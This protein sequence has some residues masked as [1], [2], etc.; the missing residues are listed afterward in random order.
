MATK[1][2]SGYIELDVRY[3]GAFKEIVAAADRA[4]AEA[5]KRLKARLKGD[6]EVDIDADTSKA[7]RE[8]AKTRAGAKKPVETQLDIDLSDARKQ[9][10]ALRVQQEAKKLGIDVDVDTTKAETQLALLRTRSEIRD[11][12]MGVKVDIGQARTAFSK[13]GTDISGLASSLKIPLIAVGALGSLPALSNGLVEVA[14]SLQKV[15]Q[16]GLVLPGIMAGVGASFGTLLGG[17]TGISDA[18]SALVDANKDAAMST[19]DA[20]TAARAARSAH[21]GLRNAVIDEEQ[22]REDLGR[23]IRDSRREL[24]DLQ[25]QMRG[26]AIDEKRAVLELQ[27]AKEALAKGDYTDRRDA[28]LRVEEAQNRVVDVQER[29]QRAAADLAEAQAK[30][31]QGSDRVVGA[32]EA[33]VRAQ[34]NVAN[35]QDQVTAATEKTSA[36]QQKSN[37]LLGELS[38]NAQKLVETLVGLKEGPVQDLRN[39]ISQTLLEGVP[40]GLEAL[41]TRAMPV[42]SSGTQ[43]IASAWNATIKD[44]FAQL[45]TEQNMGILNNVLDKTAQAMDKLRPGAE[46]FA[47]AMLVITNAGADVLPQIADALSSLA[48]KFNEWITAASQSGK[49]QQWIQEGLSAVGDLGGVMLNVAKMIGALTGLANGNFLT[50]LRE[51]TGRWADWMNSTAGQ[52]KIKE[53]LDRGK[54]SLE[55]WG[56]AIGKFLEKLP[57]II[58]GCADILDKIIQIGGFLAEHPG[59]IQAIAAAWAAIKLTGIIADIASIG[60]AILGLSGKAG[61]AGTGITAALRSGFTG[62]GLTAGAGAAGWA[63]PITLSIV[64]FIGVAAALKELD[65]KLQ[66]P[67]G[68]Q[69]LRDDSPASRRFGANVVPG[70]EQADKNALGFNNVRLPGQNPGVPPADMTPGQTDGVTKDTPGAVPVPGKNEWMIPYSVNGRW[71]V[72]PPSPSGSREPEQNMPFSPPT[73]PTPPPET[74]AAPVTT[75]SPASTPAAPGS[76][77]TPDADMSDYKLVPGLASL[78]D[79]IRQQFPG[80]K[81]IFGWDNR[82]PGTPQWHTQGRALDIGI[83]ADTQGGGNP[84]GKAL[85]DRIWAW[86]QS[87]GVFDMSRSL[88]QQKDHYNHIHAVLQEQYEGDANL[89]SEL[90]GLPGAGVPTTAGGY[91]TPVFVTNW[92]IGGGGFTGIPGVPSGAGAGIGGTPF[93]IGGAGGGSSLWDEVAKYE[94]SGN[95]SNADTGG[96]GHFGGLQFSQST[97][98]AFGG[99]EFAARPDQATREQQIEIANRT[100]FTGHGSTKPQ[101]LDAWEVI[102]KG[103]TPN[104]TTSTPQSAFM[105]AASSGPAPGPVAAPTTGATLPTFSGASSTTPGMADWNNYVQQGPDTSGMVRSQGYIPAGAGNSSKAGNSFLSGIYGMGADVVKGVIDQAAS[106]AS[107]AASLAVAGGSFGA[108][109]AGGSQAAGAAAQFAIGQGTQALKRGVDWTAQMGGIWTDALIEQLSPFGVP[110]FVSTDPTAFLPQPLMPAITSSIEAAMQQQ[111]PDLQVGQPQPHVGSGL[112]P[113]PGNDPAPAPNVPGNDYSVNMQNVQ[114]GDPEELARVMNQRQN[115]NM[116]RYTGRPST[117]G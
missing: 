13:L 78:N 73:V 31:V 36:A 84:E 58:D 45:G 60:T 16:A 1:L 88:W 18:F 113:G 111:N 33:L 99:Q 51:M 68:R 29:N 104:I 92:P 67:Q 28:L 105:P 32:N 66:T 50:W 14:A 42:I 97:W 2:A 71:S 24:E 77:M 34:Q 54:E 74:P 37:Q 65:Q 59:Y 55:R 90:G 20:A 101:G 117:T 56:P 35:A 41:I 72:T 38:P 76:N 6:I 44:M 108:G 5:E 53:F 23:A 115:R 82:P 103:L 63:L 83:G 8:I 89:A 30:G 21:D 17:L 112:P 12:Q 43:Q 94:S 87:T 91:G 95:W 48:T 61:I 79:V 39:S 75:P 3:G 85:G 27:K 64:G 11:I 49:L 98:D 102:T 19:S 62:A 22:A 81:S 10:T 52:Q 46:A 114:V 96:N 15:A 4:G 47:N 100:A 93:N 25:S 107:T 80:I 26:G 69:D 106:A 57:G 40:E 86:M 7:E 109:A 9:L 110:R 70:N 116:M